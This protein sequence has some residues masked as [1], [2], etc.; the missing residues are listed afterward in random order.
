MK[1]NLSAA[2][3]NIESVI[4]RLGALAK[5]ERDSLEWKSGSDYDAAQETAKDLETQIEGLH[6]ALSLIAA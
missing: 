2:A 6:E 1:K 5:L 3:A 4:A